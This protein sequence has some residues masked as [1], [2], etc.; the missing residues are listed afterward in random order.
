MLWYP[1]SSGACTLRVR[2]RS[3]G[4]HRHR[5]ADRAAGLGRLH[6]R[7]D[8]GVRPGPTAGLH[9]GNRRGRLTQSCRLSAQRRVG[10]ASQPSVA[11][12]ARS[13]EYRFGGV[14]GSWAGGSPSTAPVTARPSFIAF[15]YATEALED[16]QGL[17]RTG[18][19]LACFPYAAPEQFDPEVDLDARADVYSLGCTF[20]HLLT[21]SP[22]FAGTTA[23]QLMHGHLAAPIPRPS[24]VPAA[25][26]A[27]LSPVFDEVIAY[28]LA[29]DRGDRPPSCR[30]L[31]AVA[32]EPSPRC[33]PHNPPA[34]CHHRASTPGPGRRRD[35][36]P[37][38]LVR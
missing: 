2:V 35:H 7:R 19:V 8:A 32:S 17:T 29:K 33:H 34:P 16:T 22:P 37:P 36:S 38:L 24:Q 26:Q 4:R 5:R 27:G 9:R 11:A 3:G 25:R 12:A 31:A 28:A 6:P 20:Y 15:T 30:A 14:T 1:G 18:I 13:S 23:Q 21:G 10:G